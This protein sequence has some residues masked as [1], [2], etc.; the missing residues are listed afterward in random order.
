MENCV[1]SFPFCNLSSLEFSNL[2]DNAFTYHNDAELLLDDF[3][4]SESD[5]VHDD[6]DPDKNLCIFNATNKYW[7]PSE[8]NKSDDI[9]DKEAF[10][11]LHFNSRSLYKILIPFM[12]LL[13]N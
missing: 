9:S 7:L 6:I 4:E 12:S 10:R 13:I 11:I 1:S 2:F 8:F 5:D 3:H